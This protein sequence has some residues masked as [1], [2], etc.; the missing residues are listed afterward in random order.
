MKKINAPSPTKEMIAEILATSREIEPPKSLRNWFDGYV[1]HHSYRIAQDIAILEHLKIK[2]TDKILDVGS[3]PLLLPSA[4]KNRGFDVTGVDLEPD[5]FHE[6]ISRLGLR[7]VKCDIETQELPFESEV[8]DVVV[9]NEVFEHLRINLLFS[10][11]QLRR[12]M[13]PGGRILISTPNQRSANA[14]IN[15]IFH[16][17]SAGLCPN[18]FDEWTK[19]QE[20]GHMGHVREYTV[21]DLSNL[22]QRCGFK[23]EGIYYRGKPIGRASSALCMV[24]Y[25]FLPFFSIIAC[26]K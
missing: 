24:D 5:R 18:I 21:T 17:K 15:L 6:T 9:L 7:I 25:K 26:R 2:P 8:F 1:E 4:L 13:C 20:L 10:I 11:E 14:I 3:V 12:V 19:L 16:D 23:V 22:L